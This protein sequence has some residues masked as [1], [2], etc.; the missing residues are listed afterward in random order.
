MGF[1]NLCAA[2][3]AVRL[4]IRFTGPELL[5]VTAFDI[6]TRIVINLFHGPPMQMYPEG[7]SGH[8]RS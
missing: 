8:L 4:P 1:R 3:D 6:M 7:V 5:T 2:A